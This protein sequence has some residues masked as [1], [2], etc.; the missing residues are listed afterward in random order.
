MDNKLLV[1]HVRLFGKEKITYGST[2][3]LYGRN[4]ITKA[5]KLLLILLYS[6]KDGIPRNRLLEDLYG[7]EELADAANN[8]RVTTHR[9]KKMLVEAGLPEFEY[10]VSDGGIYYWD[11]PMETIVDV[12]VF[13]EL[14]KTVGSETNQEKKLNMLKEAC[15]L[16]GGEF[17]QKLSG[18]E[19]VLMESV[20][21]KNMY[22]DVLHQLCDMLMERREF[23]EVLRWVE[24]AIGMYP[25]DEWQ[26]VKID[27]YI[28]MNRYKDALK[29]YEA[30]AKLLIDELGVAPS[31]KM[32][33][34]FSVLSK[35]ISNRTQAISEIKG[36]LSEEKEQRGALFCTYPGF[37]D[38]YRMIRRGMERNGQSVFLLLCTLID[39]KGRPMESSDK[40]DEMAE[41]LH[42]AIKN[43]LRRCDSFTKYNRSQFLVMLVG[44]NEENCQIAIDR[45]V[46]NFVKEHKNWAGHLECSVSSL[47]D[48]EYQE[49]GIHFRNMK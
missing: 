23:D 3:I 37:R 29:E 27:C 9:L 20:Q 35:H 11:S 42:N 38:A 18:D 32:M 36:E 39:G 28:A 24:P 43:S 26:A 17:L 31:G 4:S 10:I 40:L 15:R 49:S 46:N 25:F 2:P 14:V 45:I 19:W 44:T 8:L 33:K 30:T 12:N 5:M 47:L 21:C 1:L 22:F 7:R 6:G 41:G 13:K 34:Q 16:Y 48:V